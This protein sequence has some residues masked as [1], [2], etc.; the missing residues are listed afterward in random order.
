MSSAVEYDYVVVGAGTAGRVRAARL[1]ED[2]VYRVLPVRAGGPGAPEATLLALPWPRSLPGV[3]AHEGLRVAGASTR[4][5]LREDSRATLR[6]ID[7]PA[8]DSVSPKGAW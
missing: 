4:W 2:A 3:R 1:S 6:V 8:A 7:E 5:A